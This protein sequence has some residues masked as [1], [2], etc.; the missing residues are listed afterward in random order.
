MRNYFLEFLEQQ[1]EG[2]KTI[3]SWKD[4]K[5]ARFRSSPTK[6]LGPEETPCSI[7]TLAGDILDCRDL[8]IVQG[9]KLWLCDLLLYD[10]ANMRLIELKG[11]NLVVDTHFPELYVDCQ[12][13]V[14]RVQRGDEITWE[15]VEIFEET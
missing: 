14:L 5:E 3:S 15:L 7:T 8:G 12:V 11:V 1:V 2:L 13:D 6:D 4:F 9:K 10:G